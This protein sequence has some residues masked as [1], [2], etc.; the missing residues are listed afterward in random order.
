M[1]R[2]IQRFNYLKYL[3]NNGF[4]LLEILLASI[5]F[6]ISIAGVY[7]TLNAVRTPVANKE[8][9]LAA[10]V[11]GKQVLEALRSSVNA[12]NSTYYNICTTTCAN[13]DLSLGT[14]QVPMP[15]P[16]NC[17]QANQPA[18]H[19]CGQA[20]QPACQLTMPSNIRAS[21]GGGTGTF[22]YIVTCA[23]GS[24]NPATNTACTTADVARRVDL[25]IN[26]PDAT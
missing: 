25:N 7:A 9:A 21:N 22:S 13:F 16:T 24:G 14:H 2:H 10:A 4:S 20:N 1:K 6:V 15:W 26:W 23:D 17:G 18:C 11:F 8:N 19:N 12:S 3:R 5:I